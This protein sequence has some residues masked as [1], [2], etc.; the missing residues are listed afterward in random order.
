MRAR[1]VIVH[2]TL[3]SVRGRYLRLMDPA[4]HVW[5]AARHGGWRRESP[6][7]RACRAGTDLRRAPGASL[8]FA[9]VRASS[10]AALRQPADTIV[11]ID[12]CDRRCVHLSRLAFESFG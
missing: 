6:A 4:R 9:D 5:F 2:P 1:R 3:V 10:C 8:V 12:W 7:W 11:Q